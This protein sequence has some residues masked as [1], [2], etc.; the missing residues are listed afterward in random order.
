MTEF[1]LLIDGT[2]TKGASTVDVIDPA[3]GR[4]IAVA[5]CADSEQLNAAV[6]AAKVAF[7]AWRALTTESRREKITA[8]AASVETRLEEFS[9]L[10]TAEQGKPIAQARGEMRGTVGL[11]RA[12]AGMELPPRILKEDHT[13]KVVEHRTPLG[14]V[15]AITPWNGPMVL[16][17]IKLAPAL[18]VG[19]TI[20]VKPAPTTPL[21]SLLL[22]ELCNEHFPRGVVNVIV[23]RNDLGEMLT[24]HPDVA[25]V[26]FTGSTTTGKKVMQSAASSVKRLTL[27]LGGNDVAIVLDDA[28]PAKVAPQIFAGAMMNAGQICVAI[29]RV[30]IHESLYEQMC[31]AL[32]KLADAAVV[33]NGK[34][35]ATEIGPL[36]NK[37]QYEKV[38]A[39]I[40]ESRRDGKVIAGGEVLE[41]P[42][43]FIRPTIVRDIPD[44]ARLVREEQ[45]GPVLP[46]L[47]YK[48]IDEVIERANDSP[49]GLGGT[50]WSSN[51]DRALAVALRIDTGVVWV[52]CHMNLYA[53][54]AIGGAKQSGVGAEQGIEGLREF[55]QRH[56]VCVSK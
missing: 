18:L 8:L 13:I 24:S 32:A 36:Q 30:Y 6:K 52:N 47:S 34:N 41:G 29:K 48:S 51:P 31:T 39:L 3:T 44:T 46:L 53:D 22:G 23:D 2:L 12:L 54:V 15:A 42:G 35:E 40:E 49:Y 21:T 55:T 7:P 25:K 11:L 33:G 50:V 20:V 37:M 38:K 9:Q 26:A 56:V 14:V 27:E 28:D 5:P 17:A 10:L 1:R 43:Y 19:N 16:L 45:F 4:I